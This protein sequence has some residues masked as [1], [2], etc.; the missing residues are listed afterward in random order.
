[1]KV[2]KLD[3]TFKFLRLLEGHISWATAPL[4]L[5]FA[6]FIP[7]FLNSDDFASNQ[8]PIIASRIQTIALIGIVSTLFLSLKLLPPKPA[9]YRHH[10]SFFMVIQWV[11]LPATTILFNSLAAVNSQT[12]LLFGWYL[13]TFDVTDK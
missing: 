7:A 8:L 9:R 11:L 13:G 4:L 1:N 12:R 2:P 3:L 5:A 6:A 10:R